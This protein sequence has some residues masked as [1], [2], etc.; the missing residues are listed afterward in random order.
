MAAANVLRL[1]D[2]WPEG[3]LGTRQILKWDKEKIDVESLQELLRLEQEIAPH[4]LKAE[5]R[6]KVLTRGS[7]TDD[8]DED[9]DDPVTQYRRAE[10][11]AKNLGKK[12]S[13][14]EELLFA[15][16]PDLFRY[17]SNEKVW[18]FGLG[19]GQ[20]IQAP[21]LL[22][23]RARDVIERD[24]H[25][26]VNFRF[27]WGYI[28]GLGRVRPDDVSAFLDAALFDE[29]WSKWFPD[30]QRQVKIDEVG[31]QRL[32]KSLELNNTPTWL[33][34]N[35][36]CGRVTDSLTVDQILT[37]VDVI[38]AKSD[39]GL[40][41]AIEVLGQVIHCVK[42]KDDDYRLQ[43]ASGCILFL[44]S[45]D[46]K[47]I[48][49]DYRHIDYQIE[50]ILGFALTAS[51]S[52]HEMMEILHNLIAHAKSEWFSF[53]QGK[54][55]VPFFKAYPKLTLDAVYVADEDREYI[56][57]RRL[58]SLSM[59]DEHE[60]I[61]REVPDDVLIKWCE[62]SPED[63]YIFAAYTCQLLNKTSD[64]NNANTSIA[65]SEVAKS[66]FAGSKDKKA[67][68]DIFCN[69]FQPTGYTVGA[70][71]TILKARLKLLATL[72]PEGKL[73]LMREI[74]EAEEALQKKIAAIEAREE[75]EE[76]SRTGSF[77]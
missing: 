37:L 5:I 43:L 22:L 11:V 63:R 41:V 68:L 29:V 77:E 71:S 72:N 13:H 39:D 60:S 59:G 6:A 64:Q 53:D 57:A 19:V 9:T 16:L 8:F 4:D 73:K 42:E 20:E 24:E 76:R 25:G 50:S 14:D 40:F 74:A 21:D 12:A 65:L 7:F 67:V 44:R 61:V 49:R 69:R 2:A 34:G 10:Q 38:A 28:S 66:I 75:A 55:L 31:Y 54:F 58:V 32:L 18:D 62:I 27:L 17:P 45:I 30:L 1:I 33:Y 70:L 46:W 56:T 3:W 26:S 48:Q 35:L 51:S 52:E 47:K 36:R 15:L 23:L